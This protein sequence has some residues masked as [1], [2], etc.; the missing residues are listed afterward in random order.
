MTA[1][2]GGA[3]L[4]G[5]DIGS[6]HCKSVLATLDGTVVARAQRRTPRGPDGHTHPAADLVRVA[7]DALGACVARAGRAPD[8]V[9]LT[10]MAEAGAPLAADGR[11][12]TPVL[13]WSDPTPAPYAERLAAA[14]GSAA[15]HG[16]T[17]VLPTARTPLAKWCA[18]AAGRHLPPGARWTWAGAT[19]VVAH[20]LTGRIGTDAT[21]AQRTM[22]WDPRTGRWIPELLAEAGLGEDHMPR[23]HAPGEPVGGVS[24]SAAAATGLRAGTPVVVAGHD[25]LVGAW[26]A[27]VREPGR[28]ADSM[29][30]AEAVVTVA[31]DPPDTAGAAREGMAWGRHADGAHWIL[32]AGTR[33]SGALVEWFCDRFLDLAG[34]PSEVRYAAFSALVGAGPHP[35]TGLVVTPYPDGRATPRPDPA[36]GL[37]VHGLRPHHGPG[38]LARA[39]LEGAAHHARWMT[40]AQAALTGTAP[41]SVTLLGGSTRQHA[42]TAI[43]A[44]VAPWP[45]LLCAEP[46]APALGAAAWAGAAAG[47]DPAAVR[48]HVAPLA[49][50]PDHAVAHR[51]DGHR[52]F[53]SH[54]TA[55]R[56]P[57][58]PGQAPTAGPAAPQ[59]DD[60][61]PPPAVSG[62]SAGACE[63]SPSTSNRA[64]TDDT[65]GASEPFPAA[66]TT[67]PGRR[68]RGRE[69]ATRDPRPVGRH[70]DP[71]D[72]EPPDRGPAGAAPSAPGQPGT[73]RTHPGGRA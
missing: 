59:E 8:A 6:T 32:L 9:G 58:V 46:E 26:A 54:A 28:V 49:A 62:P 34:A 11:A 38:D 31:A 3:L 44:A 72:R 16:R 48:P 52:R 60:D 71:G 42:W 14:H 35:P 12:L 51:D 66:G 5:I 2:T 64:S 7:L 25:H 33:S 30:T 63:D 4:A 10:G 29:G 18:L 39:L 56:P 20:A 57:A 27:G 43:K 23:V 1:P 37:D 47:F 40:E 73:I 55:P 13:A 21:L 45:T 68:D 36:A 65:P 17:G 53:L 50:D 41:I 15:L 24:A 22:A 69:P 61:A 19:D 70:A 67:A